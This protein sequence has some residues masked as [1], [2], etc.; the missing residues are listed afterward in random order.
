[1][2]PLGVLALVGVGA[3]G[4]LALAYTMKN[5]DEETREGDDILDLPQPGETDCTTATDVWQSTSSVLADP[6]V[7]ATEMRSAAQVLKEWGH[8]CNDEARQ[9]GEAC[10]AALEAR[11]TTLENVPPGMAPPPTTTAKLPPSP[12]EVPGGNFYQ[13]YGWCL[14]GM[15]LDMKTG[16]CDLTPINIIPF[17]PFNS[18]RFNTISTSGKRTGGPCCSACARGS[19]CEEECPG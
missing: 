1:M 16:L 7:D 8:Y 10:I 19:D 17:L 4:V 14:P 18:P 9:M 12:I 13:G 3:G 5:K 15:V 11:A 2:S 6:S